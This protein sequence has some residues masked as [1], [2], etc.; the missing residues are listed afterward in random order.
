MTTWRV[1][2]AFAL[3]T[4]ACNAGA[5]GKLSDSQRHDLIDTHNQWR[6]AVGVAPLRW[7]EDLAAGAQ[8]WAERLAS[9]KA[10]AME[11][12]SAEQRQ[13]AG[14]NLYWASPVRWSDGRREV[15]KVPGSKVV[16]A[17]GSEQADYDHAANECAPG[18]ACGHYTQ[19]VWHSTREVGCAMQV[20]ADLAQVWVCRYRPTGN[21]I[22]ERPY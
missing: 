9:E 22:G 11:H 18:R 5:D 17:W 20:C 3:I 10:C 14:E 4:F 6:Q 12:S 15:Q 19:M 13:Q 1:L 7:A 2:A 8:R 21:W 16:N